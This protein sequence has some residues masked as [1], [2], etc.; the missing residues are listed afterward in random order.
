MILRA[1]LSKRQLKE[2]LQQLKR[3]K[4][5]L[6][7][8]REDIL[9]REKS[10][11]ERH[12]ELKC[13]ITQNCDHNDNISHENGNLERAEESECT[14][15]FH[16]PVSQPLKPQTLPETRV[17]KR[18]IDSLNSNLTEF[19]SFLS[20]LRQGQWID[21]TETT[22][23]ATLRLS[24]L[25]RL[26][27]RSLLLTG[28]K[29][30]WEQLTKAVGVSADRCAQANSQI[31][32]EEGAMAQAK[33]RQL[34]VIQGEE[35]AVCVEEHAYTR[36]T[37]E[38]TLS[39]DLSDVI[40]SAKE[41]LGQVVCAFQRIKKHTGKGTFDQHQRSEAIIQ[42]RRCW[43]FISSLQRSD[44]FKGSVKTRLFRAY[45]RFGSEV[46]EA[47]PSLEIA[48]TLS[49]SSRQSQESISKTSE[50]EIA[51]SSRNDPM[52][53]KGIENAYKRFKR[54]YDPEKDSVLSHL[55]SNTSRIDPMKI[56]CFYELNGVCNDKNCEFQHQG[57]IVRLSDQDVSEAEESDGFSFLSPMETMQLDAFLS[58]RENLSAKFVLLTPQTFTLKNESDPSAPERT[59]KQT[60]S[61]KEYLAL[62]STHETM[63]QLCTT[64][65][66]CRYF[67]NDS[68]NIFAKAQLER[69]ISEDPQDVRAW[70]LYALEAI[71]WPDSVSSILCSHAE[72]SLTTQLIALHRLCFKRFNDTE[73]L[74]GQEF[75]LNR[76]S[77]ALEVDGKAFSESLWLLYLNLFRHAAIPQENDDQLLEMTE[78]ALQFLPSSYN[79][80]L[81]YLSVNP[82]R[83]IQIAEALFPRV[84]HF[85]ASGQ[86]GTNGLLHEIERERSA[87]ITNI[88]LQFCSHYC[89]SGNSNSAVAMLAF[90]QEGKHVD[91]EKV[92]WVPA[93]SKALRNQD[94][95]FIALNHI[96]ILL[97]E[98]LPNVTMQ[99]LHSCHTA[100]MEQLG[101]VMEELLFTRERSWLRRLTDQS[102]RERIEREFQRGCELLNALDC[103]LATLT[104]CRN[105]VWTCRLL[106]E[107]KANSTEAFITHVREYESHLRDAPRA[108]WMHTTIQ[109]HLSTEKIINL[110]TQA[111][112]QANSHDATAF[113]HLY[114]FLTYATNT[115]KNESDLGIT[116]LDSQLWLKYVE[117]L[118]LAVDLPLEM[119]SSQNAPSKPLYDVVD[120][121]IKK[122]S[123]HEIDSGTANH[124]NIYIPLSV[125]MLLVS[126]SAFQDAAELLN[127]VIL[128]DRFTQL[129]HFQQ[130]IIWQRY[131][132]IQM[133]FHSV[134]DALFLS[135]LERFLQ[136]IISMEA[137]Y[138]SN[139]LATRIRF[140]LENWN[141]DKL[142]EIE[143]IIAEAMT[144][145]VPCSFTS[146]WKCMDISVSLLPESKR[147]LFM[148]KYA[149]S[150][151][152][153]PEF[154]IRM[155]QW[156][157]S[158]WDWKQVF[159][160]S[161]KCLMVSTA[162]FDA[163][164]AHIRH[165]VIDALLISVL[166]QRLPLTEWH[167]NTLQHI[168]H[169]H[170]T[171]KALWKFILRLEMMLGNKDLNRAK[172]LSSSIQ[173]AGVSL[174]TCILANVEANA[175]E[176]VSPIY[177]ITS[178]S[179]SFVL[180][181]FANLEEI[182]LSSNYLV[183]IPSEISNLHRIRALNVSDNALLVLPPSLSR[184]SSLEI[185][186]F[187]FNNLW[188][189]S[190]VMWTN[191][192]NL[193]RL[194]LRANVLSQIPTSIGGIPSLCHLHVN[195]NL[196]KMTWAT[197]IPIAMQ[198]P[199]KL[200]IDMD[201]QYIETN[202][203]PQ[204]DTSFI[205]SIADPIVALA[206]EKAPQEA[207]E[208]G[209]APQ[210]AHE[211]ERMPLE[212]FEEGEALLETL[213]E[214]A[215][216]EEE[217]SIANIQIELDK[218]Q[219]ECACSR[220]EIK[221]HAP[222]LWKRFI[223][224]CFPFEQSLGSC[225]F[226]GAEEKQF[227]HQRLNTM[228]L[229]VPCIKIAIDSL[230]ECN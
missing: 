46:T 189:I 228:V 63:E 89:A 103:D 226:C 52:S 15:G 105:I 41:E 131:L 37:T 66:N 75:A 150:L 168:L 25:H 59:E 62:E 211:E 183:E 151:S 5:E 100:D 21:W 134:P 23:N 71:E 7:V 130:E 182:D 223:K 47:I 142:P 204:K 208:E 201:P 20:T 127:I 93:A 45:L 58:L 102:V 161:F 96:H 17:T 22:Q 146:T 54:P 148:S 91:D 225:V 219:A 32:M 120:A 174:N 18:K 163:S 51:I 34:R 139:R 186:N 129:S 79:L 171:S 92:T 215:A 43:R 156:A 184:L 48:W 49:R 35:N 144:L 40:E 124:I 188:N 28:N 207:P 44:S 55:H 24:A 149:S 133:S 181:T 57:D 164:N 187:A 206:H 76:L 97:T 39:L 81:F 205:E 153:Y 1:N 141:E 29:L 197:L 210:E 83:S 73:T 132:S 157:A 70:I 190:N 165:S 123:R 98:E 65:K 220:A 221:E 196:P 179:R 140:K 90:I 175:M 33:L 84:L 9:L 162:Y 101:C 107:S 11:K 180:F 193:E 217:D 72:D 19:N 195:G 119:L 137:V 213:A 218:V 4:N 95:F 108:C 53:L 177:G 178:L 74:F 13:A 167:W 2:R 166:E 138:P 60:Q 27:T 214:E 3:E 61:S 115:K 26:A 199:Q 12:T 229:C 10:L 85:L 209:E 64:K 216:H 104:A 227:P 118:L 200:C 160:A 125:C 67:A 16:T 106:F 192:R 158:E 112:A 143:G 173:Q 136:H 38:D 128:S 230:G 80:W 121:W 126:N 77:K 170:S 111:L 78:Q 88:I 203:P 122:L 185:A 222:S 191:M 99:Y 94:R 87:A 176:K 114:Y 30:T 86:E 6:E 198:R 169:R 172:T 110:N 117:M 8:V 202:L 152:H 42:M 14:N 147:T 145:F 68:K 82:I 109:S 154:C 159:A 50:S 31:R 113:Q 155:A 69:R 56:L 212:A 135:N 116:A 224:A 194:D 36:Q